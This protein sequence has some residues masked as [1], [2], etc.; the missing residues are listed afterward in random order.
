MD[1]F[2]VSRLPILARKSRLAYLIMM[3][4]HCEDHRAGSTDVL[5]RSRQRA[6]VIR[7]RYLAKE[8]CASCWLCKLN[9]RKLTEQLMADIP[10]HQLRPCPPFSY[11]SLDFAGPYLVRAMGNSR[12]QVKVWGL[13][14]VCQNTRAIK[15]YATAG[16]STDDFLTAFTRFTA[17]HGNPLVVVSD[18]GSQ[19][20]KAGKLVDQFDPSKLNWNKIIEGAAKNGTRWKNIQPGCQW[21]NGL[22]EAAVKLVKT[23]LGHTLANQRTLNYAELDTLFS[24]VANVVNQR[25]IAVQFYT[26]EDY[27]AI[28]PNDLLLQRSKNTVPGVQYAEEESLTKR[29]QIMKE[30]EDTW[31]RQWFVQALPQLVPYKKWRVER[32][33]L[34]VG[35]IVLV[36]YDK[37]VGKA[38][39]R[40]ARVLKVHP[41]AHKVVRTVTVGF[42]KTNRNEATLPYVPK[43]LQEMELGVQRLV[44]ICPKEE[45][46][47]ETTGT[48]VESDAVG[49]MDA[50][51]KTDADGNVDATVDTGTVGD[52][53]AAVGTDAVMGV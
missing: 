19:L 49:E 39:Y 3:E 11:I 41:D 6:W 47:E 17:N 4:A 1:L 42:R 2:G 16:Y 35:D 13:V 37:N 45:Q 7:G 51:V 40:L 44:V 53:N 31:W 12:A 46:T 15:M 18:A 10:P 52:E 32:R 8:V 22:A 24:S 21:R 25:P 43:P 30:I 5:A 33:S 50:T 48:H 29:Q 14:I 20:V 27:H 9:R 36:Q 23:T 38:D 28:T 34:Q 26:E